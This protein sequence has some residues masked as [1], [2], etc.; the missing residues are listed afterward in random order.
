MM[1]GTT[2]AIALHPRGNVQGGYYF[3]SLTTRNRLNQNQWTEL[4]MPSVMVQQVHQLCCQPPELSTIEF[5]D[6]TGALTEDKCDNV[7]HEPNDNIEGVYQDT[8][9]V[10]DITKGAD[11]EHDNMEA[12]M[13]ENDVIKEDALKEHI[14]IMDQANNFELKLKLEIMAVHAGLTTNKLEETK[15]AK[16]ANS[17]QSP[18]TTIS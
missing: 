13:N 9:N 7:N 17:R 11:Q 1:P 4:P 14:E 16:E 6:R 10:E 2:G 3:Y 5:V 18:C 8:D 15:E 12:V